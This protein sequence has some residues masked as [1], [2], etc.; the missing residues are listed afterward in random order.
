MTLLTNLR[1]TYVEAKKN[2]NLLLLT[3]LKIFRVKVNI[4]N[5]DTENEVLLLRPVSI[6]VEIKRNLSAAWYND[7]PDVEISGRLKR[8]DVL[9]N[10]ED[11]AVIMKTLTENLGESAADGANPHAIAAAERKKMSEGPNKAVICEYC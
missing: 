7:I 11:Y 3:K 9:L 8:I 4:E 5:F 2:S 1:V 6:I 10:Q